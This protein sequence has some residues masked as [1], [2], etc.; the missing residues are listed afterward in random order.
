MSIF[1]QVIVVL[2][3]ITGLALIAWACWKTEPDYVPGAQ[4]ILRRLLVPLRAGAWQRDVTVTI[5]TGTS[6]VLGV[7]TVSW[8]A[9]GWDAPHAP[10]WT[11]AAAGACGI[12]ALIPAA[13]LL[14]EVR[15]AARRGTEV[16]RA[17]AQ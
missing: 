14:A 15:R 10:W 12:L 2:T 11:R 13:R 7:I 9:V 5:L 4:G 6:A 17:R 8:A 16:M 3:G 1:L